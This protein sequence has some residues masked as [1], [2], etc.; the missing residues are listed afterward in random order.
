MDARTFRRHR[1][2]NVE[3][4]EEKVVD[5]LVVMRFNIVLVI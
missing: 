4:Q 5:I 2:T 3:D 1:K